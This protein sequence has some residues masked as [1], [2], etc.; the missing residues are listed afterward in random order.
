M[1]NAVLFQSSSATCCR[2]CGNSC[3]YSC[4][5]LSAHPGCVT[6]CAEGCACPPGTALAAAGCVE[7]A[8][9]PC[10]T[11]EDGREVEAGYLDYRPHT[12][13]VCTCGDGRW[14]CR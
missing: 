5:A 2:Q 7:V 3:A 9:C 4:A 11:A 1:Y 6:S 8:A 12:A 13:E 14:S 10:R